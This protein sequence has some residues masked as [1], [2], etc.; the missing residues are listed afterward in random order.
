MRLA[1]PAASWLL[2]AAR[3]VARVVVV[4]PNALDPNPGFAQKLTVSWMVCLRRQG[5]SK[6]R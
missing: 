4:V 3:I 6:S 2:K 5:M 1:T